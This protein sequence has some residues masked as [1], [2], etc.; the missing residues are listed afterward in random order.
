MNQ[1]TIELLKTNSKINES[2]TADD[3][4]SVPKM[5]SSLISEKYNTSLGYQICDIQPLEGAQGVVYASQK[6]PNSTD[7]KIVKKDIYTKIA[8]LDTGYTQE[9]IEDM[10]RMFSTEPKKISKLVL[11][12][13]S[14]EEENKTIVKLMDDEASI[15]LP[16]T[17]TDSNNFKTT[18][19]EISKKVADSVIKMNR[20]SYKS[21]DSF[22]VLSGK[23]ASAILGSYDS[24]DE[25]KG[26]LLFVGKV[27]RCDFY[28]N[29]FP[30]TASQY[31]PDF[32]IDFEIEDTSALDYAYVGLMSETPGQSSIIFAPHSYE[33]K[34]VPDPKT[35]NIKLFTYNRYGVILSPLHRPADG[36]SLL[37]KFEIKV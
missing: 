22:C 11:E 18:L 8:P 32:D 12:G 37:H 13:I 29:P 34:Y 9:V 2:T 26:R 19:R 36:N 5:V 28:I 1:D 23:W 4:A 6:K 16:L 35:G 17:I 27:G 3:I 14:S 21:L 7:F 30:H 33:T 15:Q 20:G 10:F 25:Q 31:N 24:S